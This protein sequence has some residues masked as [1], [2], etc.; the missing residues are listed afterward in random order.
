MAVSFDGFKLERAEDKAALPLLQ[1]T[2]KVCTARWATPSLVAKNTNNSTI[3]CDATFTVQATQRLVPRIMS[4]DAGTKQYSPDSNPFPVLSND[5]QPSPDSPSPPGDC[6]CPGIAD[7][8]QRT[9]HGNP[10]C[11]RK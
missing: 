8:R 9:A 5:S 7:G 11:P 6:G 2:S 10:L 4:N 1:T 3:E